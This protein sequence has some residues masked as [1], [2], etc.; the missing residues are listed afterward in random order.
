MQQ[1]VSNHQQQQSSNSTT[2]T[3]TTNNESGGSTSESNGHINNED[4]L[5]KNGGDSRNGFTQQFSK[6]NLDKTNQDIVRLIGQYLKN[7]GLE[8][9][10]DVLMQESGCYLEHPSATKFRQ[11]VMSGDWTKAD[12]DLK[13]LQPVIDKK[14][15]NFIEMKFLILEQKYLELLEDGRPYDALHVL[16]N[17][18]TPLQHNINRVHQLS[19]YMMCSNNHDLYQRA[20]WEGKGVV[21]RSQV[22]ERLQTYLPSS[23]MLP[24]RRLRSL[25]NQAVELQT[26]RCYC[27]GMAWEMNIENISLLSDH[28]CNLDGFPMHTLQILTDHCDEVWFCKFSP[29]GLKLATGSKDSSVIIWDVDPHK[30]ILNNRRSLDIQFQQYGVS[31][32]DWSPD[33]KLLLIGG[34][35]ECPEIVVWNIEDG[36]L[37]VRMSNAMDDSLSCG[38]FN[39]DGTRFVCGGVRGQFYLCD[40]T[41]TVLENWEGVRVN[42]L[43]FRAD[44]KTVLAADTHHRIRGYVFDNPRSDFL[45][46]H[47]QHPIMTFSV[48]SSDRL[49]LLNI[50]TQGLHLWDLEDKC[51]I[52]R[53]QGVSQGNFTIYSCFGGVHESF[54]ASGSEDYKVYIWNVKNEEPLAKLPGHTKTVNCVSWNP[55]YPSLLASASDDGTVRIWGPKTLQQTNNSESDECSSCSSSSSWNMTS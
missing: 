25:L 4:R 16:R 33:S 2:T 24:P 28:S 34:P 17:E 10:A 21:S 18:L 5:E 13:E 23:V 1:S 14:N 42:C 45:L 44:N 35:E 29:D 8:K 48:N 12:N 49:A 20:N 43:A 9:T 39:K 47:E 40:L 31:F 38:A 7:V 22:M 15:S 51:L 52:R 36:R 37:V 53:F 26:E 50:A 27:H 30:L 32:V 19:S 6:I 55:V 54:I 46:I 3:A 11:H 41:G